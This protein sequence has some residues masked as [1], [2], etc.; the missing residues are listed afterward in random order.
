MPAKKKKTTKKSSSTNRDD[1]C[2]H[3][4]Y[5][6]IKNESSSLK[7]EEDPQNLIY[8]SRIASEFV[9]MLYEIDKTP[10]DFLVALADSS[11]YAVA[12]FRDYLDSA[13]MLLSQS[14]EIK[15]FKTA[16]KIISVIFDD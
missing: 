8:Y 1:V 5:D 16:N 4:I 10:D 2:F 7:P 15:T 13:L 14:E 3:S 6:Q 9:C 11:Y 12:Q